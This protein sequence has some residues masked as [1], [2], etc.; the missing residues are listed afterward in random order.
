MHRNSKSK[1]IRIT[2][3]PL[4]Q[5]LF[6]VCNMISYG[7]KQQEH[8]AEHFHFCTFWAS[9]LPYSHNDEAVCDNHSVDDAFVR[10]YPPVVFA[11]DDEAKCGVAFFSIE[12]TFVCP[13]FFRRNTASHY[14]TGHIHSDSAYPAGNQFF[15][16]CRKICPRKRRDT[17]FF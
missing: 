5:T 12:T 7:R 10:A 14:R 13:L 16:A 15:S 1:T 11:A 6:S 4:A 3:I 17:Y 8:L 2:E 9:V